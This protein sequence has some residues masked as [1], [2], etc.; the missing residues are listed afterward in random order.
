[1]NHK[2][3]KK[4]KDDFC[5]TATIW[6][7]KRLIVNRNMLICITESIRFSILYIKQPKFNKNVASLISRTRCAV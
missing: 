2:C 6:H 7:I 3:S 5:T 1:M 4:Y